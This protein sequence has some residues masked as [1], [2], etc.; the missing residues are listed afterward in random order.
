[1]ARRLLLAALAVAMTVTAG[2][3]PATAQTPSWQH[4]PVPAQVRPRPG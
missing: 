1:M 4:V 3:S 2:M